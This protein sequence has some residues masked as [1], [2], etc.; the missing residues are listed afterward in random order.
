MQQ[1]IHDMKQFTKSDLWSLEEYA[2]KRPDFYAKHM[3]HRNV[4]QVPLGDNARLCFEDELTV[5]FQIQEMLRI[6]KTFEADGIQ[7]ELDAYNPLLPDG[8]N[9]KATFLIEYPDPEIRKVKLTQ[10]KG[11]EKTVWVQVDDCDKVYPICNE[12]LEREN[13][14][15]TSAVHFMRFE[16]S[17]KMIATLK[18][19]ATLNIG[20]EHQN[21]SV[22]AILITGSTRESLSLDF[23]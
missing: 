21:Y 18:N 4:R 1:E 17:D 11:I 12:D 19:G 10:L 14:E 16:L 23:S 6:E 13:D 5:R 3:Q 22:P 20:I 2:Q 7:E 8:N 9:W 15:K